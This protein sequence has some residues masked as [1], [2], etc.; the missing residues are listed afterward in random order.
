MSTTT[1]YG[2]PAF[3]SAVGVKAD[4]VLTF[5]VVEIGLSLP[6]VLLHAVP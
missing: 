4:F 6:E 3:A 2:V 5:A 1:G